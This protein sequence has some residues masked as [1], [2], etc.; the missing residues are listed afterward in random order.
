[1]ILADFCFL[2]QLVEEIRNLYHN[3]E[4]II[5]EKQV[6]EKFKKRKEQTFN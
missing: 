5:Q 3:Y 2:H 6:L 4:S 1:M